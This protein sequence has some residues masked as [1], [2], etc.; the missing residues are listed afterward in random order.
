[1]DHASY[2]AAFLGGVLALLSPCS[3]LLVPSFF[4]YAFQRPTQLV[5]RSLVFYAGLSATLV[6]LGA[7][8]A[9]TSRLFYGH[10]ALLIEVAG[11]LVIGMGVTQVAGRGFAVPGVSRL[12]ARIGGDSSLSVLALGG[13]YGLAGF[14]SGPILGAVLTVAAT[15]SSPLAGASLLAVYAA[16]MAVPVFAL[17]ALWDR[18]DLGHRRLLRGR[19]VTVAGRELHTTSVVSGLLFIALGATFIA[20]DG[21]AGLSSFTQSASVVNLDF[22]LQRIASAMAASPLATWVALGILVAAL[23]AYV[24]TRRARHGESLKS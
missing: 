11:W 1:M 23:V 19:T 14:C 24:F 15:A 6:P 16:G 17:A 20:Y 12:Q 7:G 3:A 8:S 5:G 13:M 21:T 2:L 10:R 4:A 18:F 9:L 22:H